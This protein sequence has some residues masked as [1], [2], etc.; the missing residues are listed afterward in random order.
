M[1]EL[2]KQALAKGIVN[3]RSLKRKT[4][5]AIINRTNKHKNK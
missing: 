4:L 3:A 5:E 1:E 2:I